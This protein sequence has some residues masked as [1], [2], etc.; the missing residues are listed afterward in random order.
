MGADLS[1]KMGRET[2]GVMI[3]DSG[4]VKMASTSAAEVDEVADDG[5]SAVS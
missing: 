5:F 1:L 3:G 2:E 4:T